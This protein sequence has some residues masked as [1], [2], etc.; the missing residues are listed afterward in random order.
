MLV[1]SAK[2]EVCAQGVS[3]PT[4]FAEDAKKASHDDALVKL[5]QAVKV[6]IQATIDFKESGDSRGSDTEIRQQAGFA[7]DVE[8]KQAQ[9]REQWVSP[10]ADPR[11]G[12]K[13]TVY[14]LVCM[15]I[16]TP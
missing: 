1:P 5:A 15:P 9:L 13:G 7:S 4:Y 11:Y 8:L 3:G 6:R 14:T 16:P 10:G 2:G 12:P